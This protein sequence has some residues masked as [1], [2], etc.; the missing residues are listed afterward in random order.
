MELRT[1]VVRSPDIQSLADFYGMLGLT[2]HY[3]KHGN[4]PYHFSADIGTTII[5]IYP[6]SKDQ[7]E[8]DK[9]LR[10]GLPSMISKR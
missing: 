6:L 10:L 1:L 5:E 2:F 4:S 3:H 8:A 9:N 7:R